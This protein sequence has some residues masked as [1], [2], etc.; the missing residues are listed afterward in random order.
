MK[1]A[2]Q[3]FSVVNSNSTFRSMARLALPA[4][5]EE[6][7]VLAVTWTDWWLTGHYFHADGDATKTAMSMMGYVMWLIPSLFAAIAIGA[8]AL[9]ARNVGAGEYRQAN[10][11]ANQ[12]FIVGAGIAVLMLTLATCFGQQFIGLMQLRDESASFASEYFYIVI[13][14]MPLIMFSIVGASCLRGAGDMVTGFIVKSIVVLTNIFI[15]FSLVT[16]WGPFPEIGW[17]GLAIGTA[18][19]HS[20]GGLIMLFVFVRG[21]AGLRL[22]RKLL[23]PNISIIRSLLRVGLPGGMDVG[24][25]LFSQMIFL[26]MINAL[27]TSAAAAHGLA[28]QIEAACFLP[29]AAFQAAAATM[30]GQFLGAKMPDRAARS[31]WWCL[32]SGGL[33]MCS[34]AVVIYTYGHH[35]AF[36]FTG[37]YDDPT[38]LTA[39]KLLK[40]ISFV[41]PFLA[42]VMILT[43]SLRGAGDTVWPFAFTMFGFFAI[44]IPL[45]AI[46]GFNDLSF[47]NELLGINASGFGWGIVGAWYAM[48]IDVIIR[49]LL[50]MW[51]F[52]QGGW[53]QRRL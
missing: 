17:K 40:I 1:P 14:S 15:S 20:L 27:G 37:S 35:V 6:F 52:I 8:T 29:G 42:M 41:M 44:R 23:T 21:R 46:F 51:R 53:K 43:G 31:G 4:L 28:V 39:S 18:I 19:G 50:A 47:I 5:A 22:K 26:A 33:I 16:G 2:S 45:A 30:A 36:F 38:T 49:A 10:R 48:I 13:W 11:A 12:S 34:M 3:N 32:L 25:L 9:V 7:L 24:V